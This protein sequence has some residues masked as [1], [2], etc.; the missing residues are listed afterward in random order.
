M[1]TKEDLLKQI[2]DTRVNNQKYLLTFI[3]I[4]TSPNLSI[5]E[6]RAM[7]SSVIKSTL[8]AEPA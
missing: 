3:E 4:Q 5:N 2:H 1:P 6:I 7:V 8:I